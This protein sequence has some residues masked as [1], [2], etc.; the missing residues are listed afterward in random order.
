M[1]LFQAGCEGFLIETPISSPMLN[2]NIA[3]DFSHQTILLMLLKYI[4][5]MMW[6][7]FRSTMSLL[8]G[9]KCGFRRALRVLRTSPSA[10][11]GCYSVTSLPNELIERD[12][13]QVMY[14]CHKGP[15]CRILEDYVQ[16]KFHSQISFS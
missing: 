4:I 6:Y 9:W 14:P 8:F 12:W 3:V 16:H 15:C 1:A 10:L 5:P 13:L 11:P 7:D 2:V